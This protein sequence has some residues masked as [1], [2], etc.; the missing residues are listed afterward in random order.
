[1]WILAFLMIL[2]GYPLLMGEEFRTFHFFYIAFAATLPFAF[3][4]TKDWHW[5]HR[6]GDYSYPIYLFHFAVTA[7]VIALGTDIE[8]RGEIVFVV[9]VVVCTVFLFTVDRPL[10]NL[11][12]RI[13]RRAGVKGP[14]VLNE[15]TTVPAR[16]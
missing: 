8:W 4:L 9:T 16:T 11:R 13:A 15:P 7:L 2:R 6:I 1:V 5:D 3:Y 10:Q 14:A 12:R